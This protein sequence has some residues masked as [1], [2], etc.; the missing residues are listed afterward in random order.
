MNLNNL[1]TET[2]LAK[3]LATVARNG[4]GR[5]LPR[6]QNSEAIPHLWAAAMELVPD[7]DEDLPGLVAKVVV[8]AVRL[9]E[10]KT[11]QEALAEILWIDLDAADGIRKEDPPMLGT[12]TDNR[13]SLAADLLTSSELDVKNNLRRP[14]LEKVARLIRNALQRH[15]PTPTSTTL[16]TTNEPQLPRSLDEVDF[17]YLQALA[18]AAIRLHYSGLS[19]LFISDLSR[20]L[21]CYKDSYGH[22]NYY[23]SARDVYRICSE[24][25]FSNYLD[26][27]EVYYTSQ[28]DANTQREY[29]EVLT[30]VGREEMHTFLLTCLNHGPT[31]FHNLEGRIRD[32][33]EL[34]EAPFRDGDTVYELYW[35]PWYCHEVAAPD[36]D[37]F[38]AK[39]G[40]SPRPD[41]LNVVTAASAGIFRTISSKVALA[42]PYESV[43]R[44]LAYRQI[45]AS[46]TFDQHTPL[47]DGRSLSE[48]IPLFFEQERT[49]LDK[50]LKAML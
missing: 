9:V 8:P 40:L 30:N 31:C 14:L 1:P 23:P 36:P 42:V 15:A 20:T 38:L 2:Q 29:H 28:V 12:G 4:I 16:P 24:L 17:P 7:C 18:E 26:L 27:I 49:E 33:P 35:Y 6:Q 11:E 43:A 10:P 39:H 37:Q 25:L 45:T 22:E 21:P 46:Y 3:D 13:Y 32:D 47:Q 34:S 50:M 44:D 48:K 5:S 19:T 41:N